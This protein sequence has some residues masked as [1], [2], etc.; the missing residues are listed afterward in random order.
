MNEIFLQTYDISDLKLLKSAAEQIGNILPQNALVLMAGEMG[1]GKTTF[2]AEFCKLK[3]I[4][5][6]QSPTYAIHQ[7]YHSDLLEIDHFD[8]YRLE[9]EDELQASGFY[10]LLHADDS[11][12]FIEWSEKLID[13]DFSGFENVF[14]LKFQRSGERRTVTLLKLSL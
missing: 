9:S 11:M 14:K 2:V 1:S 12:K 5:I 6:V 3:G 4:M 10:D 13:Y 8:L 7:R